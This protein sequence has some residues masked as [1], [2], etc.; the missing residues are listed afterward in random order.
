MY[1]EIKVNQEKWEGKSGVRF[2]RAA[3]CGKQESVLKAKSCFHPSKISCDS[4]SE[5]E[6]KN[7]A[8]ETFKK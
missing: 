8:N 2:L 7:L 5:T 3:S 4:F 1:A 6:E